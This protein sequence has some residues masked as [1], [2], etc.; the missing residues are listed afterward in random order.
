MPK[1]CLKVSNELSKRTLIRLPYFCKEPR[2]HTFNLSWGFPEVRQ[3]KIDTVRRLVESNQLDGVG[4]DYTRFFGIGT[5]YSDV[6][7]REFREKYGL[8][9]F[10]LAPDNAQWIQFRADYITRFVADLRSALRKDRDVKIF[11]IGNPDPAETLRRTMQDWGTWLERG[12]IDGVASMI[13]ERDTNNTLRS[14]QIAER[15]IRGRVPHLPMI[16]CWGGNLI[17]PEMLKEGSFKCLQAGARGVAFY[18]DD[19]ITDLGLWNTVRDIAHWQLRDVLSRPVNYLLNAGFENGLE[20]WAPGQA[21]GIAITSDDARTGDRAAAVRFPC[22]FSLRQLV[23]RGFLKRGKTL[24]VTG[25]LKNRSMTPDARVEVTVELNY[26]DGREETY[27]VPV[28]LTAP[29]EWRKF[30]ATVANVDP[31]R[32][33]FVIY[34]LSG[35]ASAGVCMVDDLQLNLLQTAAAPGPYRS[36]APR[37]VLQGAKQNVARGQPVT[38]SSFWGNG[39]ECDNAVDGDLS[40]ERYGM[41]ADWHS[42]RPA[43]DQWIVLYL[44]GICEVRRIRLLNASSQSCYRTRDFRIET[45]IDCLSFSEISLGTLPDDGRTWKEVVIPPTHAKYIRFTG[46]NG[47]NYDYAVGLKEIEIYCEP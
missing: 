12:L 20:R 43:A 28:E 9:P 21:D 7:V 18:R 10:E 47:Y 36:P 13:Y 5:G 6:I 32:L 17:T 1:A 33:R 23:D 37:T 19:A 25:W 41:G 26:E 8:D 39:Y 40:S 31:A 46:V 2:C 30:E 38:C 15:A 24:R 4:L 16:A 29:D 3:H 11:V 35:N 27:C 44:P 42:Q 22:K 34:G 45:S 14:V